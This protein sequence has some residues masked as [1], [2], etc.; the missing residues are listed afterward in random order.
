MDIRTK[1]K[2]RARLNRVY[3]KTLSDEWIDDL[4]DFIDERKNKTPRKRPGWDEKQVFLI[5]YGDM[6]KQEGEAPLETLRR[7]AMD[8]LKGMISTIHILPF[9]PYS[10]DDGFSVMDFYAVNPELGSW[11][12]VER[13]EHDF[14]LMADL[15]A[16]HASSIGVWFNEFKEGKAP[17]K[18]YFFVPDDD[19]DTSKVI[20]P[21]SSPLLTP[22]DTADGPKNVW[23]TFSADQVDLNYANPEV[24]KEML[25][26]FLFYM[27]KGIQVIRLDAIAFLWKTS[28]TACMH[29]HET[30]EIVCLFRDVMDYCYPGALLLTETN[31]PHR[32]NITYFG[33]GDEAHLIYQFA[34]PPLVLHALHTGNGSYFTNWARELS[35]P[36]RGTTYLNFTSSHDGIG[37][38]PLEGIMPDEE[39]LPMIEKLKE[40]GARV[41]TRQLGD[42]HVPYEI[43][44]TYFDALKGTKDGEDQFQVRRFLMSQTIMLS[45]QGVP[46]FY[47]LNLFGMPNDY[48]GVEKTGVNRSINRHKFTLGE[49]N[50]L[51]ENYP[52]H[53][54]ILK[55]LNKRTGIRRSMVAF[56]PET[57]QIV[58]DLGN[59]FFCVLR[60][61]DRMEESIVCLYNLTNKR[62]TVMLPAGLTEFCRDMLTW[63]LVDPDHIEM[64]PYQCYWLRTRFVL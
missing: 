33:L 63:E 22:V 59:Q 14:I 16:N 57:Q 56:S 26:V 30:H 34:L 52:E 48:S 61:T 29:E 38:R 20:R 25:N 46:A 60:K 23:T 62:Q 28:G 36:R 35:D 37:V 4:C 55:E 53:A 13:L 6:I 32:E 15:V 39:K 27:A 49:L 7:F 40:F 54:D 47:F 43:N 8:K 50:G 58:I 11:D 42:K 2:I 12:D 41:T 51:L 31:V 44:V 1:S 9:F 64:R 3:R 21:R 17:G 10:S 24:L 19:F 5:T 18:D 45:L